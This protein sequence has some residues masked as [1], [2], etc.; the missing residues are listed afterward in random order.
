MIFIE[1]ERKNL[2]FFH[3][4]FVG[5]Y[6]YVIL[7]ETIKTEPNHVKTSKWH[8]ATAR[9]ESSSWNR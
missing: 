3:I 2:F 4:N 5:F 1:I 9:K 8:V 6:V 7:R